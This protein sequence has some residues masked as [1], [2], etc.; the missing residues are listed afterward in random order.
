MMLPG[1]RRDVL[2]EGRRCFGLTTLAFCVF[3]WANPYGRRLHRDSERARTPFCG[4][5]RIA[6]FA[7]FFCVVLIAA[8]LLS[9]LAQIGVSDPPRRLITVGVDR[10][11]LMIGIHR[12]LI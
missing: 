11:Y 3:A 4:D 6:D 1:T 5:E 10:R 9:R 2:T 12:N 8:V 7:L